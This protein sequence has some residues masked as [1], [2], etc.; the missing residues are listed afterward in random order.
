MTNARAW[1]GVSK[2]CNPWMAFTLLGMQ[3]NVRKWTHTPKWTPTL[4]VGIP[5]ES[6]ILIKQFQI[7]KLIELKFF[8]HH[9]KVH[10]T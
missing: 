4:G 2:K 3:E 7:S 6:W 1:K 8:L 9:W 10:K 5:M